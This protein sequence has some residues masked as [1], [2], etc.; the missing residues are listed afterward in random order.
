MKQIKYLAYVLALNL[1]VGCEQDLPTLTD[2]DPD[3]TNVGPDVCP[4]DASAGSADFSNFVAVGNSY[5]AGVQGG[6]LYNDAQANSLPALINGQLE[7][8]GG[9][10][11][12]DQPDINA[13]LGWNLFLTQPFLTNN[14][15]PILGRLELEYTGETDCGTEDPSVLPTPQAYGVGE[16]EALPNPTYNPGFIFGNGSTKPTLNNFGVPAVVLGQSLITQT[17]YWGGTSDPRFNPFYA[18]MEYPGTNTATMISDV[19]EASPTFVLFYLGLDDFF[20]HAA[21]GGD[22]TKAP[23]TSTANDLSG[24]GGQYAAAIGSLM[25]NTTAKVVVGNFPDVF[26]FPFFTAVSYNP[27][28]LDEPTANLLNGANGFAGYNAALN[29]IIANKVAFG[30]T[31][32]QVAEIESRKLAWTASCTNKILT[33]DP[34]LLDLG[35]YFDNLGLSP[36]NRAKLAPYEQVRFTTENDIIPLRT[37]SILGEAGSLPGGILGVSEPVKDQYV[38]TPAEQEA[39]NDAR[40]AFNATVAAVANTY[41]TRVA[42]ADLD[43][44]FEAMFAAGGGY[45]NGIYYS[46]VIDPPS[47]I[48]SPDGVHPNTRGYAV[49][50][51]MFIEAINEQ[52]GSTIPLINISRYSATGLPQ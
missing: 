30:L 49:I 46:P 23:L 45:A 11:S 20:L 52:F 48:F 31:D 2:P 15:N 16:L 14:A 9:S 7:C 51:N 10:S 40:A 43:A 1:M 32:A 38:L 33:E 50:G 27:I 22:P 5:V 8:V 17:G 39:I 25:A 35:P 18:R 28:P 42:L 44:E 6:A 24:F 21:Y 13:E 3:L 12:F 29:G 34:E 4:D 37:G 47:G 41:S 36:E 26:K 19:I